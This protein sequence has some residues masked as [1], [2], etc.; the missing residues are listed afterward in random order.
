[1]AH[2]VSKRTDCQET[3]RK[4]VGRATRALSLK[5]HLNAKMTVRFGM[6]TR[7][8]GGEIDRWRQ[9]IAFDPITNAPRNAL[10]M[11]RGAP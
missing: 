7:G 8:L 11:R 2:P 5:F 4:T 1:L 6:E 9:K 3:T 10:A